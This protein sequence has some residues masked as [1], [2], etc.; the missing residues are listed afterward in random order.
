LERNCLL[1]LFQTKKK[2][3]NKG[4]YYFREQIKEQIKEQIEEPDGIFTENR[5]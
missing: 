3:S 4:Q 5:Q 1:W 2:S